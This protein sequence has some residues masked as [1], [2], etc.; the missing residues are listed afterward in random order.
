MVHVVGGV[1]VAV[2]ANVLSFCAFGVDQLAEAGLDVGLVVAF[3][4]LGGVVEVVVEECGHSGGE[5]R[6][7]G[8]LHDNV[9]VGAFL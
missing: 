1:A 9:V 6:I 2:E 3:A 8:D 5:F 4:Q 7:V